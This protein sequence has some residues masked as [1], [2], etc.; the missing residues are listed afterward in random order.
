MKAK[1]TFLLLLTALV[2]AGC[3]T[4]ETRTPEWGETYADVVLPANYVPHD[5]PPYKR[6][7]SADGKRIYGRYSLRSKG[8]GFDDPRKVLD[9]LKGSMAHDGWELMLENL[10][11]EKSTMMARFKKGDDQVVLTMTPDRRVQGSERFSILTV[12]MNP[13]F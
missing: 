10:D 7:D 12:E 6:Q 9:F 2:I 8:D 5:N 4:V 1:L 11:E 3:K 13:K